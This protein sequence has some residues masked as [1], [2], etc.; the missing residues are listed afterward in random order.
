MVGESVEPNWWGHG[1]YLQKHTGAFI[2]KWGPEGPASPVEGRITPSEVNTISFSWN[3]AQ[4]DG[5]SF[6]IEIDFHNIA[7]SKKKKEC[8]CILRAH[9]KPSAHFHPPNDQNMKNF[10]GKDS[11]LWE[12]TF[13]RP[14]GSLPAGWGTKINVPSHVITCLPFWPVSTT[15]L[16]WHLRRYQKIDCT[17]T[18]MGHNIVELAPSVT[19][20]ASFFSHYQSH[21]WWQRTLPLLLEE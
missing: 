2:S 12:I 4:D 9:T 6:Q 10:D 5:R 17:F 11:G 3:V 14:A 20:N 18:S 1:S 16:S 19:G 13:S 8:I 21:R 15:C 7:C